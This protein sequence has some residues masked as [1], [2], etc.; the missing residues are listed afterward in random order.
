MRARATVSPPNPLSNMPMG[1]SSTALRLGRRY[2]LA[3]DADRRAMRRSAVDAPPACSR[4]PRPSCG[5]IGPTATVAGRRAASS[6][7]RPSA[8]PRRPSAAGTHRGARPPTAEAPRRPCR[9][10]DGRRAPTAAPPS[11]TTPATPSRSVA[12][13]PPRRRAVRPVL[14]GRLHRARDRPTS[15]APTSPTGASPSSAPTPT[16]STATATASAARCSDRVSQPPDRARRCRRSGRSCRRGVSK[17]RSRSTTLGRRA[18]RAASA[19]DVDPGD[20]GRGVAHAS[21]R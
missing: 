5:G 21:S 18:G 1:R 2:R 4:A 11:P 15:T 9:R 12:R 16:A 17:R 13:S 20:G 14:P 7:C 6:A 8:R 19:V 10:P 3:G